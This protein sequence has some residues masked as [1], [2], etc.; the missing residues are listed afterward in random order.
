VDL[1]L[2]A[3]GLDTSTSGGRAMFGMVGVFAELERRLIRER[4]MAGLRRTSKQSGP[5][6]DSVCG[7]S[8]GR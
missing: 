3:Q 8:G 6:P 2:H 7:R 1:Y 5:M 4:I